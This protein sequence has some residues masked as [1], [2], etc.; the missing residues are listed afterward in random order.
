MSIL[1][2]GRTVLSQEVF[3]DKLKL[4][5]DESMNHGF[6][7]LDTL[8]ITANELK[9]HRKD[10]LLFI[11]QQLEKAA[12]PAPAIENLFSNLVADTR[13]KNARDAGM[14]K[15]HARRVSLLRPRVVGRTRKPLPPVGKLTRK[16]EREKWQRKFA[17][18]TPIAMRVQIE[19]IEF[20]I[21]CSDRQPV[22][23]LGV[24]ACQ[25]YLHGMGNVASRK[26]MK[27]HGGFILPCDV[28]KLTKSGEKVDL[29]PNLPLREAFFD[30]DIAYVTLQGE[31][32]GAWN[33]SLRVKDGGRP[34]MTP[35]QTSA[36]GKEGA[37]SWSKGKK[38]RPPA[39]GSGAANK[40]TAGSVPRRAFV[41]RASRPHTPHSKAQRDHAAMYPPLSPRPGSNMYIPC[42][43]PLTA[44]DDKEAPATP[45]AALTIRDGLIKSAKGGKKKWKVAGLQV[46]TKTNEN[47]ED[48][49]ALERDFAHLKYDYI[50]ASALEKFEQVASCKELIRHNIVP[51]KEGFLRFCAL[52]DGGTNEDANELV[53]MDKGEFENFVT[54]CEFFDDKHE[55]QTWCH[56]IFAVVND[57]RG[58][59]DG[60]ASNV[61]TRGEFLEA[62]LMLAS[63]LYDPTMV[64]VGLQML[65]DEKVLPTF[66]RI[67]KKDPVDKAL[68]DMRVQTVLM[69]SRDELLKLYTMY[70]IDDTEHDEAY[71][72][73]NGMPFEAFEK[74]L[75]DAKL[76]PKEGG[77]HETRL[78]SGRV[79]IDYSHALQKSSETMT[80]KVA[81]Q[82]FNDSQSMADNS[83]EDAFG[84]LS[85]PEFNEALA[86]VAYHKFE[87][88]KVRN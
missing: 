22:K 80:E 59:D 27:L 21:K 82:C 58:E 75:R 85:F 13:A 2:Y 57:S 40:G 9:Q 88:M 47:D 54:A 72:Q 87:D 24:A 45:A 4:I 43:R 42:S 38:A 35:W 26:R 81:Q 76:L 19:G 6:N 67:C 30:A 31:V 11:Q 86:R 1:Q 56:R 37:E 15:V 7:A 78:K 5:D 63:I 29:R 61:M 32:D 55:Q 14:S 77:M 46:L 51:L 17:E 74:L 49:E 18:T 3:R 34:A 50:K 60:N 39:G 62:L 41:T 70:T 65:L 8:R 48:K 83:D 25:R 52:H 64:D 20:V 36:F 44:L 79:V 12:K 84:A 10:P 23:W 66:E 53:T 68:Q 28:H 33:L 16:E 73:L 69:K 71:H